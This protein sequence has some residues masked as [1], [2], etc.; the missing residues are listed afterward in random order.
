MYL[1]C[2]CYW[3]VKSYKTRPCFFPRGYPFFSFVFSS[4]SNTREKEKLLKGFKRELKKKKK[5][6]EPGT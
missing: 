1:V 2:Y 4:L 3:M 5:K 6:E